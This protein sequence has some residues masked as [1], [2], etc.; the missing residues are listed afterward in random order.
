MVIKG[1]IEQITEQEI[2]IRLRAAQ[3]NPRIFSADSR[4]AVEHDFM[5]ATFRSMYM[6]LSAFL[7]A[8]AER[9]Q[10]LLG[11]RPPRFDAD[12]EA[13]ISRATDDFERV[14][15]KA[16]AARD[17]FLLI[18][19]PGTGKTS[20]ALRRMVER[21]YADS[22]RQIL[23]L[24]YTNRAVDEICQSVAS[25]VPAIDYIRVGSE[26]SCDTRFRDKLLENTLAE[27]N[28]RR[29]VLARMS[30]CRVYVGTVASIA[31]KTE[32][33]KLKHFD[34]VVVDEA[35][36]IL[37]PQLL[38]ILCARSAD[39]R[40]AVDKFVLIGDHKQLPAVVLQGSE[41]SE[42]H[43]EGL[44]TAGLFNLKDSLFERL[45]RFH[46]KNADS[47]AVDMLCRQGRMHPGVAAFPNREFYAGRLM[48]LDLPHQREY[49]ESPVR[50]I[51]SERD[52][53][54]TS[55]KT[56]R[57]EARIVAGLAKD[58]YLICKD[59]FDPNRTLGIIT[60]YRSQIALIRK[61][62]HAWGIPALD[63]ISVD[64][65]ERY[66]GSERDVIVYSFCVNYL[67]QLQFLS[68]LTEED[69]VQIDRKLNVALTRA[70]KQLFITGVPGILCHN[71]IYR[72]LLDTIIRENPTEG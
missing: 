64:T 7:H 17:Y 71:P 23:L 25:I 12:W 53:E 42:V 1:N 69:G 46:G 57:S 2:R 3:R 55:G 54:S 60:P 14:A 38:G 26:L 68:N 15:L 59:T 31:A 67:Y 28:N 49:I 51:P 66:Q 70:R 29:E 48:S 35:T 36:Q 47:R 11:Q 63:C 13:D 44:R 16:E 37:E 72:R 41:Q 34:V 39:G 50:F 33:F 40:N 19:P 20:R 6:G 21:F 45:Y 43:D 8:N 10:L 52:L 65:V 22:S 24:A 18:G 32:L 61:E 9:R 4:Y 27:C 5:D 56:N 62:L 30:A 58:L